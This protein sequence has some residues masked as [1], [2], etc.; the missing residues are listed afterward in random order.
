MVVVWVAQVKEK[1]Q[2][3][4]SKVAQS[5][6]KQ[7]HQQRQEASSNLSASIPDWSSYVPM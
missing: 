2:K 4:R 1:A 5:K 6:E 7:Q 3:N